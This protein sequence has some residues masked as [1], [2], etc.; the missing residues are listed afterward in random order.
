MTQQ[1]HPQVGVPE[2]CARMSTQNLHRKVHSILQNNQKMKTTQA[3]MDGSGLSVDKRYAVYPDDGIFFSHRQ[4][5]AMI[6][7]ATQMNFEDVIL[8]ER[9]QS[10]RDCVLG[11]SVY[12]KCP[13]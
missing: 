5:E 1:S 8:G 13:E 3:L 2:N 4:V 7:E 6:Q 12:M 9:S 10:R 11:D